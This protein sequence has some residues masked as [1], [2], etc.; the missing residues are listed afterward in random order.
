MKVNSLNELCEFWADHE[1]FTDKYIANI[2][3]FKWWHM[4]PQLGI[5]VCDAGVFVSSPYS[6]YMNVI[7]YVLN[8]IFF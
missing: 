1:Q 8:M 4:K 5:R 2:L 3:F 7:D 6:P